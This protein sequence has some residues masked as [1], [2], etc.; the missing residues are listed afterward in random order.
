LRPAVAGH[1]HSHDHDQG[2]DQ[3]QDHAGIDPHA[4]LDP[5]NARTWVALIAARL[6]AADPAGEAVYRANA[7]TAAARIDAAEAAAAARLAPVAGRVLVVQHDAYGYFAARFGLT[8]LGA[9][10]E[11]DAAPPG[12]QRLA[13]LRA[14]LQGAPGACIYPEANHDPALAAGLAAD[15]GLPLGPPLDPE[16]ATLPPGAD[17][18]PLLLESLAAAIAACPP[19]G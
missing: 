15:T 10:T 5:A 7:G 12:A 14:A 16:G 9:I 6:A 18:Y 4:W 2:H 11:G 19:A 13:A 3:G 8:V 17:L 1:D